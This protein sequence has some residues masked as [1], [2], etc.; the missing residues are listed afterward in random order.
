MKQNRLAPFVILANLALLSLPVIGLVL[1]WVHF[2][3]NEPL[4]ALYMVVLAQLHGS[5][6]LS[7]NNA[8]GTKRTSQ[9]CAA[10]PY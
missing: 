2:G 9:S 5:F 1:L 8:S 4:I 3:H 6:G 10:F 7:A